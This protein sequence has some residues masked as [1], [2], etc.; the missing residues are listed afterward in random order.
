MNDVE[1]DADVGRL[2]ELGENDLVDANFAETGDRQLDAFLAGGGGEDQV[3]LIGV[4]RRR[5]GLSV[6]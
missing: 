4:R 1:D 2:V 6:R 3:N 5:G